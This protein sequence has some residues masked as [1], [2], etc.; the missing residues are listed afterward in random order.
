M[1]QNKKLKILIIVLCAIF[2]TPAQY[3]A[4]SSLNNRNVMI[5]SGDYFIVSAPDMPLKA[6]AL[7]IS[8]DLCFRLVSNYP[9]TYCLFF[10]SKGQGSKRLV[11]ENFGTDLK[12]ATLKDTLNGTKDVDTFFIYKPTGQE[13]YVIRSGQFYVGVGRDFGLKIGTPADFTASPKDFLFDF[14]LAESVLAAVGIQIQ[15]EL[16]LLK[17]TFD[18]QVRKTAEETQRALTAQMY[19]TIENTTDAGVEAQ[20][21]TESELEAINEKLL[22]EAASATQEAELLKKRVLEMEAIRQAQ[23]SDTE[24]AVAKITA[25][26]DGLSPEDLEL[27]K[28]QIAII[29]SSKAEMV[30]R[31][32]EDARVIA[33]N[34]KNNIQLSLEIAKLYEQR[35]KAYADS[36]ASLKDSL[37]EAKTA[38]DDRYEALKT[39][40]IEKRDEILNQIKILQAELDK[41]EQEN[42]A[43]QKAIIELEANKAADQQAKNQRLAQLQ[44]VV[45]APDSFTKAE[46]LSVVADPT[47]PQADRDALAAKIETMSKAGV[48]ALANN[49]ISRVFADK[50]KLASEV[51]EQTTKLANQALA[52]QANTKKISVSMGVVSNLDAAKLEAQNKVKSEITKNKEGIVSVEKD[53]ADFEKAINDEIAKVNASL[54]ATASDTEKENISAQVRALNAQI[55]KK[56]DDNQVAIQGLVNR[57]NASIDDLSALLTKDIDNMK[58]QKDIL[59]D[60]T[61]KLLETMINQGS[62]DAE[63][64]QIRDDYNSKIANFDEKIKKD[65]EESGTLVEDKRVF[66][67]DHLARIKNWQD[68]ARAIVDEQIS[69]LRAQMAGM[70][71][72]VRAETEKQ[73]NEL[74]EQSA[75][76]IAKVE[77]AQKEVIAQMQKEFEENKKVQEAQIAN[78]ETLIDNANAQ[79]KAAVADLED[80][81]SKVTGENQA[82]IDEKRK[83]IQVEID[84]AKLAS[85]DLLTKLEDEHKE[86]LR[87][88]TLKNDQRQQM[89]QAYIDELQSRKAWSEAAIKKELEYLKKLFDESSA[90]EKAKYQAVMNDTE[91]SLSKLLE[92][93]AAESAN[94]INDIQAQITAEQKRAD[95]E[96]A[97]LKTQIEQNQQKFDQDLAAKRAELEKLTGQARADAEKAWADLKASQE[98]MQASLSSSMDDAVAKAEK[99]KADAAA[100]N[101]LKVSILEQKL[102]DLTQRKQALMLVDG[103]EILIQIP[104]MAAF[105]TADAEM[106]SFKKESRFLPKFRLKVVREEREKLSIRLA[107]NSAALTLDKNDSGA[108]TGVSFKPLIADEQGKVKVDQATQ[109]FFIEGEPFAAIIKDASKRG[110]IQLDRDGKSLIYQ[111]GGEGTFTVKRLST[112]SGSFESILNNLYADPS[113][114]STGRAIAMAD[115]Y[116]VSNRIFNQPDKMQDFAL[117]LNEFVDGREAAGLLNEAAANKLSILMEKMDRFLIKSKDG[118]LDTRGK[119]E[120]DAEVLASLRQAKDFLDQIKVQTGNIICIRKDDKYLTV[121]NSSDQSGRSIIK[122]GTG[123]LYNPANALKVVEAGGAGACA[124]ES[125]DGKVR[126]SHKANNLSF[127]AKKADETKIPDDQIFIISGTRVAANFKTADGGLLSIFSKQGFDAVFL[128]FSTKDEIEVAATTDKPLVPAS[129]QIDQFVPGTLEYSFITNGVPVYS[130][131]AKSKTAMGAVVQAVR[132]ELTNQANKNEQK[133]AAL[134]KFESY[135]QLYVSDDSLVDWTRSI[136]SLIDAAKQ[137]LPNADPAIFSKIL[138]MTKAFV[139]EDGTF[140]MLQNIYNM[141]ASRQGVNSYLAPS[142]D[143]SKMIS[144]TIKDFTPALLLRV[145]A[146]EGN[147]CGL[148]TSSGGYLEAT[149]QGIVISQSRALNENDVPVEPKPSQLFKFIGSGST[150]LIKVDQAGTGNDTGFVIVDSKNEFSHKNLEDSGSPFYESSNI[151]AKF[152]VDVLVKDSVKYELITGDLTNMPAA[153]FESLYKIAEDTNILPE[154][155]TKMAAGIINDVVALM[156]ESVEVTAKDQVPFKIK[157][158]MVGLQEIVEN[159]DAGIYPMGRALDYVKRYVTF[160]DNFRKNGIKFDVHTAQKIEQLT[161]IF[162]AGEEEEVQVKPKSTSTFDISPVINPSGKG[163]AVVEYLSSLWANK[164]DNLAATRILHSYL[165]KAARAIFTESFDDNSDLFGLDELDQIKDGDKAFVLKRLDETF[166]DENGAI[167]YKAKFFDDGN[168]AL[169][170]TVDINIPALLDEEGKEID[171]AQTIKEEI[172]LGI[173]LAFDS[174][175]EPVLEFKVGQSLRLNPELDAEQIKTLKRVL[176]DLASSSNPI[177]KNQ[178][179]AQEFIKTMIKSLS[180]EIVKTSNKNT[181]AEQ[182]DESLR[183]AMKLHLKEDFVAADAILK[184]F[185]RAKKAITRKERDAVKIKI[186][187]EGDP[188]YIQY[189]TKP[190][191]MIWLT[192][193]KNN[194]TKT[195]AKDIA[196]KKEN[197]KKAAADARAK[198]AAQIAAKKAAAAGA[199]VSAAK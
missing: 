35:A 30:K 153:F 196:K 108:I 127:V 184:K 16:D 44:G 24:A 61:N 78:L 22:V 51:A 102:Q 141:D 85:I 148:I 104:G 176:S 194:K 161:K 128:A 79:G 38:Q 117:A 113:L 93:I 99:A 64:A 199:K 73:I 140:L 29:R 10:G 60:E 95:D 83:A 47:M 1:N 62:P 31:L 6:V 129:L 98:A 180:G 182:I 81:L 97:R 150:V 65:V 157:A 92:S 110:V 43:M 147:S 20:R 189:F 37:E 58:A 138:K 49:E 121:E 146:R 125:L 139:L 3:A 66:N 52:I 188:L 171:P 67:N 135:L 123:K 5:K 105:L 197:L 36:A 179:S 162:P 69:K 53:T 14:Q 88:L 11:I 183:E 8:S 91:S 130:S 57:V 124:L 68:S 32:E 168:N 100:A 94:S 118:D 120:L 187:N 59:T 170:K 46:L 82:I 185:T 48:L 186:W 177:I 116:F 172:D 119:V 132:A 56:R 26:M 34:K 126:L 159:K 9:G 63:I 134:K 173:I 103:E 54:S 169:T 42:I 175:K 21:K 76:Q 55:A 106:P 181:V 136:N 193:S 154:E 96:Q 41:V 167:L 107:N 195:R 163:T 192:I 156:T 80:Q 143:N 86:T 15:V 25:T 17:A 12:K 144:K 90:E 109:S 178:L 164:A 18:E 70:S 72:T 122:F 33:E 40:F 114:E 75:A 50:K 27:A 84:K 137:Q 39:A 19:L 89:Q 158:N 160:D 77:A 190:Q 87:Q 71:E 149:D 45:Y 142:D 198:A 155:K 2:Y 151:R 4:L 165:T 111:A 74:K 101:E 174:A 131:D 7:N 145:V 115:V 133:I 152:D 112:G 28:Q 13:L 166:E 23:E 191:Q